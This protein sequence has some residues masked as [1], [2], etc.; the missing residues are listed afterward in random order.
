METD[1]KNVVNNQ[2]V[3]MLNLT[4]VAENLGIHPAGVDGNMSNSINI[5]KNDAVEALAQRA[6]FLQSRLKGKNKSA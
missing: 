3:D 2:E 5:S 6:D 4:E 1:K